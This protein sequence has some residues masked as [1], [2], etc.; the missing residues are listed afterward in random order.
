MIS[1]ALPA[2]DPRSAAILDWIAGLPAGADVSRALREAIV[3]G[4]DI[5]ASLARIE[6]RLDTLAAGGPPVAPPPLD[7]EAAATLD[8]LLD[9][10]HLLGV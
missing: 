2:G 10:D 8:A 7:A 6:R 3:A 1:L 9:F 4:V 5:Q